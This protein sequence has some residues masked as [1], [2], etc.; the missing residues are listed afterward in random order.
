VDVVG[1]QDGGLDLLTALEQLV[2]D[3]RRRIAGDGVN[4]AKAGPRDPDREP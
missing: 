3:K 4:A 2:R 1:S